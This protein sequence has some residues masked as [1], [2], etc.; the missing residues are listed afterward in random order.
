[1]KAG[2]PG[3]Q[4]TFRSFYLGG[5]EGATGINA[6]GEWIDQVAATQHD[7]FADEDYQRLRA[8][9]I[10]TARE[11]VRW[12]LV[13]RAGRYDWTSLAP[14]LNAARRYDVEVV[15][16]LFHFG[17]PQ[18]VDLASD[19]FPERFAAYCFAAARHIQSESPGPYWFT[20]VNEPSYF[21][22]AAGDEA[23]F[24]PHLRGARQWLKRQLIR[25]AIGGIDAIRSA[26]RGAQILN[27]DRICHVVA[28][29]GEDRLVAAARDCNSRAVY[30]SLD[31]LA[32]RLHPELGGSLA[33]LGTVGVNHHCSNQFE[34]GPASGPLAEDDP[35][36]MPLSDLIREV[37]ERYRAEVVMSETSCSGDA[38]RRWLSRVSSEVLRSIEEGIPVGGICL[39]PI[40]SMPDWQDR[41]RWLP[42]GLWDLVAGERGLRRVVHRPLLEGLKIALRDLNPSGRAGAR[43]PQTRE[44]SGARGRLNARGPSR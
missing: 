12:P 31:M 5:F 33:H 38:R 9:G 24:A 30:E 41:E 29:I 18:E 32:G 25:A 40:L 36:R 23:L 44:R 1:M 19:G 34:L 21:A 26:C 10:A 15:W 22:S 8:V 43:P 13:D 28:P 37:W 42:M 14:F 7:R 27:V 17:Y 2:T 4:P 6:R 16:D 39:Y 3:V 11:V 20:P 35:R